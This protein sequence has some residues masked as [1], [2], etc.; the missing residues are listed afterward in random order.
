VA[1]AWPTGAQDDGRNRPAFRADLRCLGQ[2]RKG[3]NGD[4]TC[5]NQIDDTINNVMSEISVYCH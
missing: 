3:C 4:K 5:E 2:N 1:D